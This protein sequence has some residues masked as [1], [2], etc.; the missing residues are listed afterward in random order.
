M[1][2]SIALL[3][4]ALPLLLSGCTI[5]S[6]EL[7]GTLDP[8]PGAF[9]RVRPDD[10]ASL[11]LGKEVRVVVRGDEGERALLGLWGGR[12][13]LPDDDART[14]Y[15]AWQSNAHP[16]A[17]SWGDSLELDLGARGMV[18]G[19]FRGF[20]P[21]SIVLDLET[22]RLPV[23]LALVRG[24]KDIESGTATEGDSIRG[25][26]ER[27]ELPLLSAYALETRRVGPPELPALV[28]LDRFVGV[29][30]ATSPNGRSFGTVIGAVAD[31]FILSAFLKNNFKD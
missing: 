17:P 18:R 21:E 31:A 28:P 11:P 25:W 27:G 12:V 22:G 6:S 4:G 29:E 9:A 10:V 2:R 16:L 13:A 26:I 24:V 8:P 20:D 1:G 19:R 5:I 23:T 14:S 3:A 15:L 30:V 7:G